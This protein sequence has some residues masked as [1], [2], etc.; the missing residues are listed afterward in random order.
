LLQRRKANSARNSLL[1]IDNRFQASD[2][3]EYETREFNVSQ[4]E[5]NI[6]FSPRQ[7]LRVV[8]E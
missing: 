6:L 5:G 3:A 8:N 2:E 7:S 4:W 1:R